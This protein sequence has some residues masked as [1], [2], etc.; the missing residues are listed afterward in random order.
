MIATS[1]EVDAFSSGSM[2]AR[3]YVGG[4]ISTQHLTR[5]KGYPRIRVNE[6]EASTRSRSNARRIASNPSLFRRNWKSQSQAQPRSRDRSLD[7]E[8]IDRRA[9]AV[10]G[11]SSSR[12]SSSRHHRFSAFPRQGPG[13]ERRVT[14]R[15]IALGPARLWRALSVRQNI[16]LGGETTAAITKLRLPAPATAY[17]LFAASTGASARLASRSPNSQPRHPLSYRPSNLPLDES[18]FFRSD[19]MA[20]ECDP[21]RAVAICAISGTTRS[22]VS[23]YSLFSTIARHSRTRG[24]RMILSHILPVGR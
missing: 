15:V 13:S 17:D 23:A 3:V 5:D 11:Y 21:L 6:C 4:S 14:G 19:G 1:T 8:E 16:L 18:Q 9:P 7:V 24:Q 22:S 12:S 20:R 10:G 2:I